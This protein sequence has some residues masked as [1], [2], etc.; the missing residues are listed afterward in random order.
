MRSALFRDATERSVAIL[1]QRFRMAYWTQNTSLNYH[2]T[3][4]NILEERWS[5][6]CMATLLLAIFHTSL[7]YHLQQ[8]SQ[9][10]I[11]QSSGCNLLSRLTIYTW[12]KMFNETPYLFLANNDWNVL[13]KV[14]VAVCVCVCERTYV[15]VWH[16]EWKIHV[17]LWQYEGK[18]DT[19]IECVKQREDW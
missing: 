3:L 8:L 9:T 5:N 7:Q 18:W 16:W 2:C 19:K 12:Y 6:Q 14:S 4:H 15:N 10:G 17:R 13:W 1:Y 11:E